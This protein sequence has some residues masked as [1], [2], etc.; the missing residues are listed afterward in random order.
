MRRLTRPD[1]RQPSGPPLSLGQ[2]RMVTGIS[3]DTIVRE[4]EAGELV[5]FR[6][7]GGHRRVLWSSARAWAV[8]IGVFQIL[9][10][11]NSANPSRTLHA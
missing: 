8:R 9:N 3:E 10:P 1:L 5:A 6:T 4:I 2:I 11:A 7:P